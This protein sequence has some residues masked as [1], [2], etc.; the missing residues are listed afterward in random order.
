MTLKLKRTSAFN[1]AL[2]KALK[3][4]PKSRPGVDK[5]IEEDLLKNPTQGD[6]YPGFG[7][8]LNV[9]KIRLAIREYKI[10][11]R[12]GLRIIFLHVE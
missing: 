1:K 2:N 9:R 4:Y 12:G 11:K 5:F 6:Q 8:D 10:G 3:N 7:A